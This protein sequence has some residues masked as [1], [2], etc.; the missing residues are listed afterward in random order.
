MP[1]I[2]GIASSSSAPG[3]SMRKGHRGNSEKPSLTEGDWGREETQSGRNV[4]RTVKN[5]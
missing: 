5:R 3:M 1:P 4:R 2:S